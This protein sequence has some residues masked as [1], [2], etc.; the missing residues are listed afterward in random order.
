MNFVQAQGFLD[1]L[2]P[3]D[4]G[5]PNENG[6]NLKRSG[7]GCIAGLDSLSTEGFVRLLY[8]LIA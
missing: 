1:V 5:C 8:G 7:G 2:E 6:A 3:A 4:E